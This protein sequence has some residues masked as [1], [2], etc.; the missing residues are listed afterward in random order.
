MEPT[1]YKPSI[2]KGAGIYK[3]GAEGGGG[4]AVILGPEE[5]DGFSYNYVKIGNL[6]VITESLKSIANNSGRSIFYNVSDVTDL[7]NNNN[8]G[9]WRIWSKVDID[10]INSYLQNNL[11]IKDVSL[12][13]RSSSDWVDNKNGSN[14]LGLNFFPDGYRKINDSTEYEKN[15]SSLWRCSTGYYHF[16]INTD[17]IG[18]N[19]FIGDYKSAAFLMNLRLVKD[20]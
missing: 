8:F 5:I 10:Y 19:E 7:V 9:N 15:I 11:Y 14:S 13:L 6:Y 20:V 16:W 3:T 2:Y 12:N 18:I 4:G 1:I 17:T